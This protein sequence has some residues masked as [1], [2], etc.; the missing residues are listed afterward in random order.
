M[1]DGVYEIWQAN[2]SVQRTVYCTPQDGE[3]KI[4]IRRRDHLSHLQYLPLHLGFPHP[5]ADSSPPLPPR[6]HGVF[7][8][9]VRLW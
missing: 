7:S 6:I 2:N 3:P 4:S 5:K 1:V 8:G 9:E